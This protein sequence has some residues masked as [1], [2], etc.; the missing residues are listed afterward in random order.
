ME[1]ITGIHDCDNYLINYLPLTD[2]INL[3]FIN[4]TLNKLVSESKIYSEYA[5]LKG[6]NKKEILKHCYKKGLIN[7]LK[8]YYWNGKNIIINDAISWASRNGHVAVLDWFKESGYEF[9][10][11][12]YAI[13][14]ASNN[15]HIA[16]LDWFK[17]LNK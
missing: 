9:K 15:G 17:K 11:S 13:N 5:Q 1:Y 2:I 12:D 8:N 10:Y 14:L 7:I 16:V 3:L 6:V 4:N